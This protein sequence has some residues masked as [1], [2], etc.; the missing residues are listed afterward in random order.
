GVAHDF[1]NMLTIIQGHSGMLLTNSALPRELMD[2]VQAICAAS[3][4]AAGLTRQ[5]LMFSRK[6]VMQPRLLDLREVVANMSKMLER[7]LGAMVK[8]EVT[9]PPFIPPIRADGGMIEQIL[10]NLCVNARD[11]MPKGGSLSISTSSLEIDQ[12]YAA[13]HPEARPGIFVCLR[14]SD[15]G[16]GMDTATIRRIFEPFF[17]TKE[18]GKGTGLGL[19]TVYGIVKQHEGWIEVASQPGSGTTFNVFFPAVGESVSHLPSEATP[20]TEVFGGSETILLVEDEPVVRDLA[21]I[22]LNDC[23]YNV[24]EAATGAEALN[25]WQRHDGDIHL[26]ITDMVMPEGISGME[27]AE[28]LH[29]DKPELKIIF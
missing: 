10:M 17:T 1:N 21:T 4:R 13:T 23:G 6:S 12:P 20:D 18:V 19:A 22:I 8:L 25:L 16:I 2:A 9:A 11:A 7:L 15:D 24:L 26:L 14:V 3:E 27:L 29:H 5:L 28:R